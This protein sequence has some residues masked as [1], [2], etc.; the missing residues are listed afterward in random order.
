M[1]RAIH[2]DTTATTMPDVLFDGLRV[3]A[4][5]C[6]GVM[7]DSTRANLAYYNHVLEH[8]GRSP[9]TDSQFDYISMHTADRAIAY[10]FD[11]PESIRRAQAYRRQVS[12]RP[13]LKHMRMEPQLKSLLASLHPRFHTAIATNRT[14]TMQPLLE[15]F[16]LADNFDLVVTSLDVKRPKPDPEPLLKILEHF[17]I[18]PDQALYIGDSALDESAA[19]AAGIRL[20]AFNN[21]RLEAALHIRNFKELQ[22]LLGG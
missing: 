16:G 15:A 9:V 7:F 4:F 22:D 1:R 13:F 14:D 11:D 21:P 5:D 17:A 10:L 8:F 3:V 12:Y 20:V 6:D 19:R 18:A 2:S